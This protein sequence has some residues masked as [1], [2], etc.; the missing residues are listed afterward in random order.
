MLGFS[1]RSIALLF[2][3]LIA[4]PVLLVP[5]FTIA[6]P[7]AYAQGE[8]GGGGG[9]MQLVL[10]ILGI[11]ALFLQAL[12]G[13]GGS[14]P[15]VGT[16][17]EERPAPFAAIN[18]TQTGGTPIGTSG[19]TPG[20]VLPNPSQ[21]SVVVSRNGLDPIV[22]PIRVGDSVIFLNPAGD[23]PSV[24][25]VPPPGVPQD[26]YPTNRRIPIGGQFVQRFR[27]PGAFQVL[28]A[29]PTGGTPVL[30]TITVIP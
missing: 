29:V 12:M 2:L 9:P 6:V 21:P 16:P 8:G 28:P 3:S 14:S 24:K 23:A 11:V 25:I 7:V 22:V 1:S 10:G 15:Q 17:L 26:P 4:V 20:G 27:H 18:P 19:G 5:A 13:G 30:G